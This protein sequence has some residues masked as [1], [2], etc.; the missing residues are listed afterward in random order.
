M[1]LVFSRPDTGC[2]V[3]GQ[4]RDGRIFFSSYPTLV[5]STRGWHEC[6]IGSWP[7]KDVEIGRGCRSLGQLHTEVWLS[8][9]VATVERAV[10]EAEVCLG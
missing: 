5:G 4:D 7:L 8:V 3:K 1:I 10:L 6:I 9:G 2:I